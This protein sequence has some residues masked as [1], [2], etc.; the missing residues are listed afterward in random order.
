CDWYLEIAK[1]MIAR[2][3]DSTKDTLINSLQLILKLCHPII[4]YITEEIW[5]EMHKRNYT[6]DE[7]LINS[8]FPLQQKLFLDNAVS[9]NVNTVMDIIN[10][11]RKT[12]SDLNIHPKMEIDV[13]FLSNQPNYESIIKEN[14]F[15]IQNLAKVNKIF[16]NEKSYNIKDC[17]TI[18]LKDLKALIPIKKIIDVDQ[19]LSRLKKNLSLLESLLDK[20]NQKINNKDFIEKAPSSIIKEN[21]DKKDNI[22]KEIISINELMKYLSD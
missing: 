17:I 7:L 19:E 15:I 10:S 12:R 1:I 8:K 13:Y 22:Q 11:I 3:V 5:E 16:W 20:V 18:T 4:P 14:D 21:L 9:M 2:G 6:P